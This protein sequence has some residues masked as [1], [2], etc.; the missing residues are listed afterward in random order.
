MSIR[1]FIVEDDQRIASSVLE[2]LNAT[3]NIIGLGHVP[4]LEQARSA[5]AK[6]RP[7][8]LIVD[9][10]LA[11]GDGS[12]LIRE[13]KTAKHAKSILVFSAFG[14]ES[15]VIRAIEAGAD[16]YVLKGCTDAQLI[17]ALEQAA[18]GESPISPAIARHLLGRLQKPES[19]AKEAAD[20]VDALSE[21]EI[22]VLRLVAQGFV[23]DEIGERLFI[24]P[25][26]VRT[27]IRHIYDKLHVS[28]R[29]HAIYEA[30]KR[31]YI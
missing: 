17:T 16:G 3:P 15:R 25:H 13:A 5:I 24:S 14:E 28:R 4:S 19:P 7:D 31:G 9:L 20:E 12:D 8:V 11:D 29:V 22:D 27:H 23:A 10:Q 30:Q 2:A 26:T 1:V 6:A 21:R 18:N